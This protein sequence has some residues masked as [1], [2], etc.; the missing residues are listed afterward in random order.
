M[1]DSRKNERRNEKKLKKKRN[2]K[3]FKR[4]RANKNTH[5]HILNIFLPL[6]KILQ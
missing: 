3:K 2:K 5:L 6:G 4:Q 1:L